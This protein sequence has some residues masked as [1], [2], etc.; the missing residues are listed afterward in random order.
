M[1]VLADD[2]SYVAATVGITTGLLAAIAGLWKAIAYYTDKRAAAKVALEDASTRREQVQ[3]QER[4]ADFGPLI[5]AMNRHIQRLEDDAGSHNERIQQLEARNAA[6]EARIMKLESDHAGCQS[7][8]RQLRE[9]IRVLEARG[10]K[11]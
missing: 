9:R 1:I 7:E 8:N 10:G 5:E 6:L 4:R 3:A 2:S 11:R